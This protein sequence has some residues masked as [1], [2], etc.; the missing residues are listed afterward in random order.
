M[1]YFYHV[2]NVLRNICFHLK[3][4]LPAVS[5]SFAVYFWDA[6]DI[7]TNNIIVPT[8]KTKKSAT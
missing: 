7:N 6:I 2:I 8:S 4:A 5:S 3:I 1:Y